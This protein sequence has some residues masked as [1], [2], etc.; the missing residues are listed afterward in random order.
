MAYET[1]G[2][3]IALLLPGQGAQH[4]GMAVELY[5]REPV[6]SAVMDEF[7]ALMGG[8]GQRLR[9]NWLADRPAVLFD[10]AATA[11]P[12]LFAVG[13]A[14]GSALRAGGRQP[15]ALLGHSV[16]ELA[17]AALADVVDLPGAAAVMLARS[18][19]MATAPS[20]GLLAVGATPA[21]LAPYVGTDDDPDSVVIGARNAPRQTVLAGPEPRL[22][23]VEHELLAAGWPSRR[24][25]A[26]Q[27]FHSP[28]VAD[29]ARAFSAVF[30]TMPLGS[31]TVPIW[32][33][34]TGQVVDREQ[35]GR[36]EFWAG[37]LAAPVLFWPALDALLAH[38]DYTLVEAG[39][40]QGLSMLARRHPAVRAGR[41]TVVPLLPRGASGSWDTWCAALRKLDTAPPAA[42][43]SGG[44]PSP[45]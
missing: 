18:A 21:E 42:T 24:V 30:E 45:S 25:R 8:P 12:L 19:V 44:A 14:L 26:R 38:G 1:T 5:G 10:D 32:S 13:Y 41:S 23:A 11:Q 16:G 33:T 15:V 34:R 7:F 9:G 31:P 36:P 20:G 6:F 35:A 3:P 43:R 28:A 27:P 22:S 40:G 17:A 37:Q 4:P 39:P 29:Q 2:R